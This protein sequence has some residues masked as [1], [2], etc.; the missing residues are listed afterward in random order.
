[1]NTIVFKEDVIPKMD[2]LLNLYRDAEWH[3]YT[4][5]PLQLLNAFD[6]SL[7]VLTAWDKQQLV[8]LIRV[9]G[10][11]YTIIYIQDLLVLKEYQGRGIGSELLNRI[12][13]KYDSIRQIVVMT[14]QT[15]ETTRFYKKNGMVETA[16]YNGVT[17]VKYNLKA[18]PQPTRPK[19][20]APEPAIAQDDGEHWLF[21]LLDYLEENEQLHTS[22]FPVA[23]RQRK[24]GKKFSIEEHICGMV[25]AL[26]SNNRRWNPIVQ[27]LPTI[28]KLFFDYDSEVLLRTSPFYLCK[29]L[30]DL[31]CG[32]IR[33]EDQMEALADN[34][35]NFRRIEKDHVSIDAFIDSDESKII[36]KEL[37]QPGKPYKM[38]MLGEALTWEY[39]RNV[40]V[41]GAKPDT[42]LRRFLGTDRMGTAIHSPATPDEVHG[43][44]EKLSKATGLYKAEI[45]TIIWSF[46]A[47]GFGEI[48]TATPRCS[49]CPI[50][51][52]CK[53]PQ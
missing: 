12:L 43:Q 51:K 34:I 50:R 10:D 37:S 7:K 42:H 15:K 39:L 29:G 25:Y 14:D 36:M 1:M 24:A 40:G 5:D 8:G 30:F 53:K 38:K 46:S 11:L 23:V 45:D 27:H 19:T 17:F 13:D 49:I 48:C 52:F 26:L 32:N 9:V 22:P 4:K 2:A 35:R 31:K 20:F 44:V 21:G 33:T 28:D 3:A 47:D 6:H 41:D 16:A 18:S